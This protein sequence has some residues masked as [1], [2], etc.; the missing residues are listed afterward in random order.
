MK[1]LIFVGG[2]GVV[3]KGGGGGAC[4]RTKKSVSKQ[5]L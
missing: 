3:G 2:G 1:G 5:A 4:N